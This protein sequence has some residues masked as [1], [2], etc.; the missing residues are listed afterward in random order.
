MTP[1]YLDTLRSRLVKNPPSWTA[2]KMT[3]TTP[4]KKPK[5]S[6]GEHEIQTAIIQYLTAKK[7]FM[8]RNNTGVAIHTGATGKQ[9][10]TSYGQVGSADIIAIRG[11]ICYGIEVKSPTGKLSEAQEAWGNRLARAGGIYV[12]ARSVDDVMALL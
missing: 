6:N 10:R 1:T 5:K 9:Y 8:W 7:I 4:P 2:E 3:L 11:G 12:I